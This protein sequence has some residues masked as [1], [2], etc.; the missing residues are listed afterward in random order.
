MFVRVNLEDWNSMEKYI[1]MT[2]LRGVFVEDN[3]L[4]ML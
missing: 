4:H 1:R 2:V 3:R